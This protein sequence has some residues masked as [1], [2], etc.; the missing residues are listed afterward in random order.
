MVMVMVMNMVMVM[1]NVMMVVKV[2]VVMMK[3]L[4]RPTLLSGNAKALDHDCFVSNDAIR[5]ILPT[6]TMTQCN[7]VQQK[8]SS[9]NL[10][11]QTNTFNQGNVIKYTEM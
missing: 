11:N 7:V 1:V 3:M 10:N 2:M 6:M 5:L 9:E 8:V 4:S